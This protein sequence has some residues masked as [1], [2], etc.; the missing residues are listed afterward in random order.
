M[1]RV[2]CPV[3]KRQAV[4]PPTHAARAVPHVRA[5]CSMVQPQQP[6][7]RGTREAQHMLKATALRQPRCVQKVIIYGIKAPLKV[8]GKLFMILAWVTASSVN[9][10][11]PSPSLLFDFTLFASPLEDFSTCRSTSIATLISARELEDLCCPCMC[12][13]HVPESL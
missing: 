1:V 3:P 7:Q 10:H 8:T 12:S 5:C 4:Q 9:L 11:C 6:D 2:G 13:P